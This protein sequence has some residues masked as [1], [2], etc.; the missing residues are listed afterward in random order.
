[1]KPQPPVTRTFLEL[2]MP[3]V[4][5]LAGAES[6]P[7]AGRGAVQ[8]D[9]RLW[10]PPV[11]RSYVG[12]CMDPSAAGT[13]DPEDLIFDGERFIPGSGVGIAYEHWSR[14]AL[15]A[16]YVR[17]L[18]VLD[19]GCGEG[20]GAAWMARVAR[21]VRGFDADPAAIEHAQKRYGASGVKLEQ[22]TV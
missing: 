6:T 12:A 3:W 8:P 9:R 22:A 1:M 17:G 16:E 7:D 14:Y 4:P 19:V 10:Q 5:T 13:G 11:R 21:S 2:K 15:A 20:Y 18:D